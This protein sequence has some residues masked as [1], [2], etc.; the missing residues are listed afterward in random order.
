MCVS[1]LL[2]AVL[3]LAGCSSTPEP[4][5]T[6]DV[7]APAYVD[8]AAV[9]GEIAAYLIAGDVLAAE[10]LISGVERS[11]DYEAVYSVL[12]DRAQAL[13]DQRDYDSSIRIDRFLVSVYPD[14]RSAQ[15]AL[16]YSL[17]LARAQSG[18]PHDAGT[19]KEIESIAAQLRADG[20]PAPVWVDIALT[21][22]AIDNGDLDAARTAMARFN[23]RWDREP[24]SLRAYA[25]ELE[26]FIESH[27][28]AN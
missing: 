12:F 6:P 18:E 28:Q 11:E 7:E 24:P 15:E 3:F 20:E 14:Q 17:W 4:A 13:A 10:E 23:A 5:P 8:V 26:R 16:I 25:T 19:V 9:A 2:A 27:S 21:Q 1:L 22:A